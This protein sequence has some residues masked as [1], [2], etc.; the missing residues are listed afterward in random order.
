MRGPKI[1]LPLVD[2]LPMR[3]F[4]LLLA[5]T[6]I[7]APAAA[8]DGKPSSA[9]T[10]AEDAARKDLPVSLERIREGLADGVAPSFR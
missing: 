6:L 10:S 5:S 3:L 2:V 9:P 8:Q 4:L 7:G 1:P